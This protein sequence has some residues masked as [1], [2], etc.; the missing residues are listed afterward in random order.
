MYKKL[1]LTGIL[2]SFFSSLSFAQDEQ[3]TVIGSLI[4]GTPIDSGSPISVFNAE[5][6]AA[7]G[8]LNIVELIK[9]VPGSS[10]M[11]G[12]TNQF[13]S[14]AAE[15]ISNVNLRG[16]GTNRT[17]V[18]INGKRQVT[19][20]L[21]S[22]AGR[23]VN[24]HDLPMAA[25][26]RIEILK[27]G[28]AATYGSD[29]I[30]GVVNFITDSTFEGLKVNVAA[31]GIPNADGIGNEFSITYGA[32]VGDDVNF[33][34][35]LS[36]QNKNQIAA[37]DT[38]YAIRPYS[39]SDKGGWS[40]LGNPPT[41]VWADGAP[42]NAVLGLGGFSYLSDPGCNNAGGLNTPLGAFGTQVEADAALGGLC[43]FQYTYFDNV[44]EDQ[45]NSQLWMEFNGN[46]DGNDWHF[47]FA[48][49]K[50]DVP[51]WA[52]SPSYPPS[53]P[54]TNTIPDSHPAMTQLCTDYATFCDA[55]T[56]ANYGGDGT[57]R[58]AYHR[59]RVRAI[60]AAGNPFSGSENLAE[61]ESRG[62]E[63][64]RMAFN[65]EGDLTDDVQYSAGLGYSNSEGTLTSSDTRQDKFLEGLWGFG[66]PNCDAHITGLRTSASDLTPTFATT[67]TGQ[68][69]AT[70]V[71]NSTTRPTGCEYYNPLSNGVK[72]GMQANQTTGER[73]GVNPDYEASLANSVALQ[74]YIV[75]RRKTVS[76]SELL[77]LDFIVQGTMGSLAGGDAAWAFGYERRD[78]NLET[79]TPSEAGPGPNNAKTDIHNGVK[80]PC[81]TMAG[82]A[83]AA[84]RAA[85]AANPIG[86]FMFLA[87]TF[88][89]DTDQSIDSLFTEFALP[90]TDTFDMQLALRY[91]D[92][93]EKDSID[94]KVVMRWTP[95][96]ALTLRFTGQTTFRAAHPDE[97]SATRVTAL[98][99][100]N[101]AGAFKAVDLTGNT[102][103]DP[104]EATTYNVGFVT[105]FGDDRWIATLDYY[106][107]DFKNPI[108]TENHQQLMN[109]YA[110]G[111]A[112]KAAV[113]SQIYGGDNLANDGS[114][115]AAAV[116]RITAN[117]ING[118]ATTVNG[119]D[120]YIKYEDDYANGVISAGLEANYVAKYSVDAY[121]K[122]AVQ[123]AGAY[124]CAGFF[125]IENPCRSMP[126]IKGK[127]F[128][129][130]Q[131][132]Q[133]NFYGA[134][135]YISSY[136]DRRSTAAGC[137]KTLTDGVCTEIA[138]HTTVDATYTYSWD[139]QFDISFSVYNLTDELPPFTVWEMNYD[140]YTHSPLGR[141]FKAGF[142]YRMQ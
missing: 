70:N 78:Y 46:A 24:L 107:F 17:L 122:G 108:I 13:G 22:G 86:L 58:S 131:E 2:F 75:D 135:N 45:E 87:P 7:Q 35:S 80:Y 96:D 99:Y 124:E 39:A 67:S 56:D 38:D 34:L 8:N 61:I 6:I 105:D 85:C 9:M 84:G 81:P 100:V 32:L 19:A 28:A 112:G 134:I 101:Q 79:T 5:E 91:E 123:I 73:V 1:L 136:D 89:F 27:E 43:R 30:A 65:I 138:A 104:E 41:F 110:A 103:L 140:A 15:G 59:L 33:L 14:N 49:G 3:V 55:L 119:I 76:T 111:G 77:T 47:E 137:G 109:A 121:M 102:N 98:Q 48:Y 120:L 54:S 82:N 133:H 42:A 125:N 63:T 51:N 62:Y 16:L 18:L 68:A 23:S 20:P 114:F 106:D 4:K 116:G 129:N 113:Q 141:F 132:D 37:K 64:Y 44:Q 12:E 95:I 40:T 92:Y 72:Q 57:N 88:E 69:I 53:N 130:Y 127:F 139:D 21:S 90:I 60:G 26:S 94:P 74:R 128:L 66:G 97:T 93:G 29:A 71:V 115:G 83:T 31:K 36:Q 52:T 117:Y 11:D 142:T 126:E 118:P 25:L 50:T 10:G